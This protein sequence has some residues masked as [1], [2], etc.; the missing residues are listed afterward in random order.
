MQKDF[1][2]QNELMA[3]SKDNGFIYILSN[4]AYPD[5]V[6][7]GKTTRLPGC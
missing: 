5:C 1:I 2:F 7:I 3:A 4:P 6:K